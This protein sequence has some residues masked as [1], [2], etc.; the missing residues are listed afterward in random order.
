MEKKAIG[1][2]CKSNEVS[3]FVFARIGFIHA[4]CQNKKVNLTL[5]EDLGEL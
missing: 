5:C 2:C 3:P 4:V 1:N